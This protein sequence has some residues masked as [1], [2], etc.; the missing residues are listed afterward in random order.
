M[1]KVRKGKNEL[2]SE[3]KKRRKAIMNVKDKRGDIYKPT[4]I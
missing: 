3:E 1:R 2:E 4:E